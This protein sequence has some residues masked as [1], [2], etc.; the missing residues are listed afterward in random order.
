MTHCLLISLTDIAW[1][2][3]LCSSKP[4]LALPFFHSCS[5]A[6]SQGL[7]RRRALSRKSANPAH[8][9]ACTACLAT[10]LV[11]F[12]AS[13]QPEGKPSSSPSSTFSSQQAAEQA[14]DAEEGRDVGHVKWPV[15]AAY[16]QAVGSGLVA[17]VFLSITLMQVCLSACQP[18]S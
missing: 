8:D 11:S 4:Q 12:A 10:D 6:G 13:Q 14:P 2:G 15:Y 7:K 5:S 1:M 18:M 17:L 9:C 16:M 3:V